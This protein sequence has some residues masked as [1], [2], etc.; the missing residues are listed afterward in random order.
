MSSSG[1]R[2]RLV[3]PRAA[4]TLDVDIELPSEGIT[5]IFGVSGAG[6]TS[7]LRCIAGLDRAQPGIVRIAGETW[8]DHAI[9]LSPWQRAV[10]Y[11]FQ[12]AS[13]FDHLDVRGNL[14]YARK[15]SGD[16]KPLDAAIEL[17]GISG[18]LHRRPA[19]LSGGE[20]QRVAI[21]RALASAPKVLLLDEPLASLDRARRGD[22]LAW[23]RR[24]RDEIRMPM[25][26]VTHSLEEIA[27]LAD[28]VVLLRQGQVIASDSVTQ[29]LS[30]MDAAAMLG[31]EAGALLEGVIAARDVRWH[32]ARVDVDGGSIWLRDDG[33][34][35]G[36]PVRVRVLAKDVSLALQPAPSGTSS[37]QNA[38]PCVVRTIGPGAHPSQAM[39]QLQCGE[40][41]LLA[42]ISARAADQLQLAPGKEVWA[43]VKTAALVQ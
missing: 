11:V 37:I 29:V 25:L 5:G 6:K 24:L 40:S 41:L 13:L 36:T 15:R 2:I 35:T 22:I 12:E 14:E 21:A 28:H 23:L 17:L 33:C 10:G 8:Q 31:D 16:P 18:M 7:L 19:T 1:N 39:V 34:A 43:Q 38:L 26:Y 42:R 27:R 30:G 20:R 3:L 32:L 9:F 4:F